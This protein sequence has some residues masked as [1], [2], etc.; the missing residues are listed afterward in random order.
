LA[1]PQ[2]LEARA[3]DSQTG[4]AIV[5]ASF[6]ATAVAHP[7]ANLAYAINPASYSIDEVISPNPPSS[8][9]G[10]VTSYSIHPALPAGLTFSASTGVISGTPTAITGTTNYTVSAANSGGSTT[11]NL[12]I[13]T[14]AATP[15][16]N[17]I[18]TANPATYTKD[19]PI[20]ANSPS[21][22]GGAV[23]SYAVSPALPT[24]LNLNYTT[25]IITGT[26]T[27]LAPSATYTVS[28]IN[29]GGSTTANLNLKV[30]PPGPTIQIQPVSASAAIGAT[31]TFSVTASGSTT[32][33]Y[34][35]QKNDINIAGANA[36][37]YTTPPLVAGDSGAIFRVLVQDTYGTQ[38]NSI[39]A[40]LSVFR[41]TF[42]ATG[43]MGTGRTGHTATL[44]PNGKV[45]IA[46]GCNND[47]QALA[48]AELYDPTT[49]TFTKTGSM[50]TGRTGH[51]AT[52]LPT[53]KVLIVGGINHDTGR[54]SLT[55][56]EL[57][58][59]TTGAFT[60]TGSMGTGRA[61]PTATLLSNGKVLITG[62]I[63]SN[64]STDSLTSTEL[65]DPTTES[66]TVTGS[67]GAARIYHTATL[68]PNGKVLI[69]GGRN[70]NSL[71][72]DSAELYDPTTGSFTATGSLER[73]RA[74]HTATLLSN[75]KV[76]IVEGIGN[77]GLPVYP[78]ELYDPSTGAF[79]TPTTGGTV[80][81]WRLD[82]TSTL[83]P[84]GKVLI[85]GGTSYAHDS[86]ASAELYDPATG[87]FTANSSM[88][89]GRSMHTATRLPN[90]NVLMA[91][92]GNYNSYALASAELYDPQ[93]SA[94][95]F[96]SH[97]YNPSVY[98][99]PLGVTISAITPRGTG[100][101]TWSIDPAL[102]P[103]LLFD[104]A[105][106]VITG[107][108]STI[109]ASANAY[110]VSASNGTNVTSVYLWISVLP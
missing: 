83:L 51:T 22:D 42:T 107:T 1:E 77:R 40:T 76:L 19:M 106:G 67:L 43:S 2:R 27:V 96:P 78:E 91:G 46:A 35:W 17:L 50:G 64:D 66:F 56:A 89:L 12:S 100:A 9:G 97:S 72:L 13:T 95:G 63:V 41:G 5:F 53:G 101:T 98:V 58:D 102:P 29:S 73:G 69:T 36:T 105:T 81:S 7:P 8:G 55:S 38:V 39:G 59:P 110:Q 3:V 92:G 75:G 52:L 103:G 47:S 25:G 4:V 15:P 88:G 30:V 65:Y 84:N 32:L 33:S 70:Y 10:A 104:T 87:A 99:F 16:S 79:I 26:P 31:A 94:P 93:D 90:G 37:S 85:G 18:Y 14:I 24:G 48:N 20:S 11:A 80:S 34:Q 62:G 82:H 108:P 49:G 86:L 23:I 45:L 60:A 74:G 28:A 44:L 54:D 61:D 57:Y 21:H 68:L 71:G 109:T 6:E